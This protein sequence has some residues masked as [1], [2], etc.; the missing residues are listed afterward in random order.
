MDSNTLEISSQSEL[1]ARNLP[2]SFVYFKQFFD[3]LFDGVYIVN[4]ERM[5]LYWN[6]GAEAITGYSQDEAV[7]RYCNSG[8]IRSYRRR[9]MQTVRGQM[10]AFEGHRNPKAPAQSRVLRHKDRRRTPVALHCLPF[11][12]EQGEIVGVVGI[13][14]DASETAALEHAYN[15]LR[16]LSEK[17]ALTGEANRRQLNKIIPDKLELLKRSGIPFSV[18]LLAIDCFKQINKTLGHAQG[19]EIV[20]HFAQLLRRQCRGTD[21]IGRFKE[22][23]FLILFAPTKNATCRGIGGKAES[24][25]FKLQGSP[26]ESYRQLGRDRSDC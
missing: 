2:V 3:S 1:A 4:K 21:I 10:S 18:I 9:R 7:G 20:V 6:R 24:R 22:G 23:V 12:N 11:N 17:D 8:R 16:E 15:K 19:D 26:P 5:I 13:F 25:R 14:R